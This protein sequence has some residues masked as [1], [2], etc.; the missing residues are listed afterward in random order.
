MVA[1]VEVLQLPF[2]SLPEFMN[3][4]EDQEGQRE[5]RAHARLEVTIY[6]MIYLKFETVHVDSNSLKETSLTLE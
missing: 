1:K 6:C 5:S 4:P 2:L 3:S